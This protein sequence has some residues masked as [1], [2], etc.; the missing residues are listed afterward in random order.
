MNLPDYLDPHTAPAWVAALVALFALYLCFRLVRGIIRA[1]RSLNRTYDEAA[2][3]QAMAKQHA[4]LHENDG[5][6]F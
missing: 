3:L 2:H 6:A 5:R 1:Y 4:K